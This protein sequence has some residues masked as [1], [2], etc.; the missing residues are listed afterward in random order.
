V[1]AAHVIGDRAP[2]EVLVRTAGG[3]EFTVDSPVADEVLDVAVLRSVSAP[4]SSWRVGQAD[5]G[6]RWL[7][8]SRPRDND[9]LL[10]GVVSAV[11]RLVVNE[12]GH[13]VKML[14]L[15]VDQPLDEFQGYSGGAVR[16]E[17]APATV[18]GVLCEQ[19]RSRLAAGRGDRRRATNVLYAVPAARIAQRFPLL[20]AGDPANAELEAV[21]RLLADRRVEDADRLLQGAPEAARREA[22]YWYWKARVA[23]A[24]GNLVVAGEYAD[25]ALS[26]DVSHVPTI[27]VKV[28]I[29]LLQGARTLA[30]DMGNRSRDLD[31]TLDAW[32]DC[33][34]DRGL[35]GD[36]IRTPTEIDSRCPFPETI[37]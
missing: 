33:L 14:Q 9:P 3:D 5:A 24:G 11:D 12:G 17:S 37:S 30:R 27:A 34:R 20:V 22:V 7:V 26:Y 6:A 1:T 21:R 32:L 19:V 35:F 4:R 25:Q 36:G 2:A 28:R 18:I 10:G 8:G 31:P 23:L 13:E 29:L 15:T 16:L